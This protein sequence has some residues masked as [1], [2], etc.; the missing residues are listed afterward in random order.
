M[1]PD[2]ECTFW[3]DGISSRLGGTGDE[4]LHCCVA[5]DLSTEPWMQSNIDLFQCVSDAG[6]SGMATLMLIGVATLGTIFIVLTGRR[7]QRPPRE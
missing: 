5:H 3:P 2:L 1:K 6:Y 7:A 4:W